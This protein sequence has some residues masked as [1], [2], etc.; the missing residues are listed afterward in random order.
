LDNDQYFYSID[1]LAAEIWAGIDGKTSLNEIAKKVATKHKPPAS[2]F[3]DDT[4]KFVQSLKKERLI[5]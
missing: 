5:Q 1:G 3:E 4:K 2:K